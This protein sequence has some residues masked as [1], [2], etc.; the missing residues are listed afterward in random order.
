MET[1]LDVIYKK[2]LPETILVSCDSKPLFLLEYKP[3]NVKFF[4]TNCEI[5]KDIITYDCN[6]TTK[7]YS[8]AS[9]FG[10]AYMNHSR[11]ALL[12]AI[13]NEGVVYNG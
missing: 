5:D 6:G 13:F 12:K 11:I 1:R 3:L 4:N 10:Y 2:H 9:L 7:R 8:I